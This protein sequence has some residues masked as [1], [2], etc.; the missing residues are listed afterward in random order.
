VPL[1]LGPVACNIVVVLTGGSRHTPIVMKPGGKSKSKALKKPVVVIGGVK[2]TIQSNPAKGTIP[3]SR[4]RR[5]VASVAAAR[6][7]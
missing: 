6:K 5:A 1:A 4:L 7:W 3:I 2:V